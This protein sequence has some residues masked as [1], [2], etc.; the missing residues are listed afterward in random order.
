MVQEF[1][2]REEQQVE[3]VSQSTWDLVHAG[4][5]GVIE[6]SSTF[7]A[8]NASSLSVAGKTG[9]AQ[10]ST[11]HADHGLFAAFAPYDDPEIAM[12]VRVTNGYGSTY[13][14]EVGRGIFQYY[15][16]LT[17]EAEIITGQAAQVSQTTFGD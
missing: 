17:D 2:D 1:S 16:Q 7:A 5:R 8:V 10:Q 9:T 14:L 4:M 11:T 15:Y 13:A 3:G 12:T 6:N